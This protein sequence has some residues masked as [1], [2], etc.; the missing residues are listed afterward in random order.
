[1]SR[2]PKLILNDDEVIEQYKKLKRITKVAWYF[3]T[4][5]ARIRQILIEHGYLRKVPGK[6]YYEKVK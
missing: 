2:M 5:D 1:M 3:R 4:T 6:R